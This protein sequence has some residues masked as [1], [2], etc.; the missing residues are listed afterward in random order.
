MSRQSANGCRQTKTP[1]VSPLPLSPTNVACDNQARAGKPGLSFYIPTKTPSPMGSRYN[2]IGYDRTPTPAA[3]SPCYTP[4]SSR[5]STPRTEMGSSLYEYQR[6]HTP[7][8]K[9]P[10]YTPISSRA[11]SPRAEMVSSLYEYERTPTPP[12]KSPFYT[13]ISSRASSQ[14]SGEFCSPS[15]SISHKCYVIEHS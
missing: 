11:S 10:C 7:S 3:M 6:T 4:I 1:V 9:S 13:P 8:A 5:A 14:Y 12:S 15:T 2:N